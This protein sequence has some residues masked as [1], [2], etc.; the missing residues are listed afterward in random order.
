MLAWA[1]ASCHTHTARLPFMYHVDTH[2]FAV[3][4]W[5]F[6]MRV[7]KGKRRGRQLLVFVVCMRVACLAHSLHFSHSPLA[8]FHPTHTHTTHRSH[9]VIAKTTI[10]HHSARAALR[11]T[12]GTKKTTTPPL[13]LLLSNTPHHTAAPG[14]THE[15]S[16]PWPSWC[17]RRSAGRRC[18]RFEAQR[19]PEKTISNPLSVHVG[20]HAFAV[21]CG[22][23]L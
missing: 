20:T 23:P 1:G 12:Q 7:G 6:P 4:P 13:L 17:S 3:V 16:K 18:E 14:L 15:A 10:H 8:L 19:A 5:P 9:A 22:V 2:A 21:L 11:Y